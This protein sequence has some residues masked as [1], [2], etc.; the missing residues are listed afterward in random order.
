MIIYRRVQGAPHNQD[1]SRNKFAEQ[2]DY[3]VPH[4]NI[5]HYQEGEKYQTL[6]ARTKTLSKSG[7]KIQTANYELFIIRCASWNRINLNGEVQ[8]LVYWV[9]AKK[10]IEIC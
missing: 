7:E 9:Q 6:Y 3:M 8:F 2:D 5:T 4:H 1:F 10:S